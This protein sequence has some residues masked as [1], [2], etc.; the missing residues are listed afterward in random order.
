[1]GT[2]SKDFFLNVGHKNVSKSKSIFVAIAVPW[3]CKETFPL[4][5]TEFSIR[6]R[7][8]ISLRYPPVI[9]K[10]LVCLAYR[11]YPLFMWYVCVEASDVH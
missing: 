2:L 7:L 11:V 3:V 4:N 8:S 1:M 9:L 5:W 10:I 6:R